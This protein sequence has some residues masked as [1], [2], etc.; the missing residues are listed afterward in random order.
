MDLVYICR[1]GE[2][3]ELRYSIR[4]A[5]ANLKHDKIWVVGGKPDWYSGNYIPVPQV[6]S[7]YEN[8][9]KNM[10]TIAS[11]TEISNNFVLMN[12]DFF[13]L[14]RVKALHYYHGGSIDNKIRYLKKKYGTSAYIKLLLRTKLALRQFGIRDVLDYA[15]HIP[16][17]MNRGKLSKIL[18]LNLSWRLAYG[19][20]Y[21]VGGHL[22]KI[23]DGTSRDVKIYKDKDVLSGKATN[24]ISDT[25]LS[26][27]D[28]SFEELLPM[29]STMFPDPSPW[30]LDN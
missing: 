7:K 13:I 8:A 9:K 4:S 16:F 3:E 2:N 25:F 21:Q 10:Q 29:L 15:L 23:K 17:K 1:D 20:I 28:D 19:N 18:D 30:E 6:L 14:K 22:V 26:S 12:D 27:N 11:S 24:T 5:V